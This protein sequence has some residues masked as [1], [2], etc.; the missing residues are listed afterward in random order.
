MKYA[1]YHGFTDI[2]PFEV[3]RRVSDR[4]LDIREMRAEIDPGVVLEFHVGGFAAHCSNSRDQRWLITPEPSNPVVRIRL[5]RRGWRD[6][7]G[8]YFSVGS[9][10]IKFYDFNF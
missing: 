5:G 8:R 3:V 7:D 4:T 9:R 1:N 10:P 6:R 2:V